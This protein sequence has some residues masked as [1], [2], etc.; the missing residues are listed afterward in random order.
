MREILLREDRIGRNKEHFWVIGLHNDH[1]IL[2]IELVSLGSVNSSYANPSEVFQLASQK[3]AVKV[4]LVHNHPSGSLNPSEA[5][6]DVTD[7]L[8]QA[9][10]LIHKKVLDHIIIS[11]TD[12]FSFADTGLLAELEESQEWVLPYELIERGKNDGVKIGKKEGLKE[13][14]KRR[15]KKGREKQ[16]SKNGKGIKKARIGYCSNL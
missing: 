15:K 9:G 12:Y 7:R 10:R 1:R 2:Y 13:R 4:I 8:I 16:N 3:L 14:F 5:D 6:K 11:T